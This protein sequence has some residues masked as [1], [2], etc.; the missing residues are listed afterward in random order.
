MTTEE[1][2]DGF[3]TLVN[4]YRRRKDFDDEEALDTVEF[5][6][7]EKSFFLTKAQEELVL[8]FYTGK[9]SSGDSFES[10]EELRRYLSSLVSEKKLNPITTSSGSPLGI[11]GNSK[12]F[13]LPSDLWFITYESV[14]VSN[15]RC[16]DKNIIKV[17]PTKQDEYQSIKDNPYRGA[18]GRR[19]LRLDLSDGIVE[20]VSTY[21]V[22]EYYVRYVKRLSPIIVVELPNGL[23]ID[24]KKHITECTLHES[25]H[26]R[27]L[28][29]AVMM[30]LRSKGYKIQK[31]S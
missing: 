31:E 11:E 19:A 30:A 17:Y 24:K 10:S 26:R 15:S 28:D 27:I 18:N 1:F 8:G 22:T 5:S 16:A 20:I 3:D 6:E 12:F 23:T 4:S 25:L 7:Y 13:T 21:S 14:R 9:N 29:L 2:S